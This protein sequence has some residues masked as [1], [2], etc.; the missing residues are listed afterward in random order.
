MIRLLVPAL[1]LAGA[2]LL[3]TGPGPARICIA[4]TTIEAGSVGDAA[5]AVREAFS[6]FLAGPRFAITPLE[7]RLE[8]QAR[9]EARADGCPYLLLTRVKHTHRQSGGGILG[10]AAAGAAQQGAWSAGTAIGSVGGRVAAGA[11][12]GAAGAA[13]SNYASSIKSKDELTLTYRLESAAGAALLDKSEKHKA[14]SDGEDLLTPMVQTASE[15]I[16]AAVSANQH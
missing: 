11:A 5:A 14:E 3:T 1:A 8:S 12:A 13:A 15:G 6:G 7:A 2:P 10:R 4:P 16:V 9:E